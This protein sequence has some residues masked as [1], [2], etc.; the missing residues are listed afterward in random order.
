MITFQKGSVVD[1]VAGEGCSRT[2]DD[3]KIVKLR[4][5]SPRRS[6]RSEP[7]FNG[8]GGRNGWTTSGRRDLTS[9]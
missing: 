8:G 4:L 9:S 2:Y 3:D 6:R 5:D 7:V 1:E